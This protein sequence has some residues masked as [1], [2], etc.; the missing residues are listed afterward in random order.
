MSNSRCEFVL[1]DIGLDEHEVRVSVWLVNAGDEVIV[2][3]RLIEVVAGDLT[4]DLP[5]PLTGRLVEQCVDE[6]D[7]LE[8]G[9]LLGWLRPEPT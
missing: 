3:D 9:Q 5:A 2:G 7:M 1:P 4:I 8:T 6:D